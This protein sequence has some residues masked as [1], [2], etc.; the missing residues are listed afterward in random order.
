MVDFSLSKARAFGPRR[1]AP[2]LFFDFYRICYMAAQM[3]ITI[4]SIW[5]QPYRAEIHKNIREGS[6]GAILGG[7]H[8]GKSLAFLILFEF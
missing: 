1:Q 4:F 8:S 7:V 5:S 3:K 2:E 6:R